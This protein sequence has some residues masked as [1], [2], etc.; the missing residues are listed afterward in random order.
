MSRTQKTAKN[1]SVGLACTIINS[2]LSFVLR[3]VFIRLLGLEYAGINTLFS[4]ILSILN[5]ADLGF[6]N[7]IL[8]RLYKTISDGDDRKTELY[9]SVYKKFCY[10]IGVIVG[11]AGLCCIP[12]LNVLVKETPSF[13]EPLWSLYIIVLFTGVLN[14]LLNYKGVLLIAKQD[15]YIATIIQ[16]IC[17]FLRNALQIFVLAVFKN[18]YLYLL[19]TTFTVLLQG[20]WTG[21][22][23]N[24]KYKL[25]WRS[26]EK[27]PKS[28]T[29]AIAK[30]VG[31]LSAYKICRTIDSTIDTFLISKFVDVATTAIYGSISMVLNALNELLG[32]FNDGMIASVGDLNAE[33]DKKHLESV[34]YQS[35]HFT[36][37]LYGIITVSLVPF[38]SEFSLLWIGHTLEINCIYIMLINFMMYGFGLNVATFRN[39]M[40]IFTKGW[41]RPAITALLNLIFSLLLVN[42]MGLVGTLIGTLIARTLTLVWYDPWLVL[43]IGM[44][45][46]P[47]KYYLRY[48]LYMA[49][50]FAVSVPVVLLSSVLPPVCGFISLIWHG[51]I[52]FVVAVIALILLG[53]FIPEQKILIEKIL[54]LISQIFKNIKKVFKKV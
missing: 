38:I 20:I 10:A 19:V 24:K 21:I 16:Y 37:L 23:S 46:S 11:V 54:A 1:A 41:I 51:V 13:P 39:S 8:F 2:G 9:L 47:V 3:A 12:F 43:H 44:K 22:K 36:F 4:D 29:R 28:E 32:T 35:F 15:R 48:L 50:V 18:I 31:A 45:K 5:L 30:D 53:S 26:K 14:H 27:L 52:Y 33:D 49:F 7:A 40:G 17:I 25:S 34:F 6:S 42:K